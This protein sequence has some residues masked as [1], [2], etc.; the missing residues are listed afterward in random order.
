VVLLFFFFAL[1]RE[2]IRALGPDRV[3]RIFLGR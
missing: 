2:F 1:G 3:R